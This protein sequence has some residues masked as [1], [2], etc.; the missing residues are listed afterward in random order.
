MK[1]FQEGAPFS[2]GM[3][4]WR[5]IRG[6]LLILAV[7]WCCPVPAA[8]S[9]EEVVGN[10]PICLV[11]DDFDPIDKWS[12][13]LD[14]CEADWLGPT[15]WGGMMRVEPSNNCQVRVRSTFT[16]T[17]DFDI[18]VSG[19]CSWSGSYIDTHIKHW[20]GLY[21]AGITNDPNLELRFGFSDSGEIFNSYTHYRI[22]LNS[23]LGAQSGATKIFDVK[24]SK[25][26]D[27][28]GIY[29][30][31]NGSYVLIG[32]HDVLN[33][34]ADL[35]FE[36]AATDGTSVGSG[37]ARYSQLTVVADCDDPCNLDC[38][39]PP[40]EACCFP[41]EGCLELTPSDCAVAGGAPQGAGSD[42][43]AADCTFLD[44]CPGDLNG[45]GLINGADIQHFVN[46]LLLVGGCP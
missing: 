28:I 22:D 14:W 37:Y 3:H 15:F 34:A 25:V 39:P 29:H 26:G 23:L 36:M 17:G 12:N 24:F 41:N 2:V 5:R 46:L 1:V 4:L 18:C 10:E 21:H 7:C 8:L 31:V 6:G 33:P 19:E 27:T 44:A 9:P 30:L 38:S 32:A 42:C 43:D 13:E 40:P 45:D 35:R 16:L 20:V 11:H